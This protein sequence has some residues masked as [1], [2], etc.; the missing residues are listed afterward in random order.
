MNRVKRVID[1]TLSDAPKLSDLREMIDETKSLSPASHIEI[2][3][4]VGQRGT[5][6]YHIVITEDGPL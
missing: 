3:P 5:E 4:Y 1:Y 2:K 6:Y